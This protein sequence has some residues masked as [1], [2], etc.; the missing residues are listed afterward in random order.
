MKNSG[1]IFVHMRLSSARSHACR[2][3]VSAHVCGVQRSTLGVTSQKLSVHLVFWDQVLHLYLGAQISLDFLV[4]WVLLSTCLYPLHTYV[5]TSVGISSIGRHIWLF[6][7]V[8]GIEF[9]SSH[10]RGKDLGNRDNSQVPWMNTFSKTMFG[11]LSWRNNNSLQ[12]S[13]SC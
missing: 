10:L 7:W 4:H 3:N 13:G 9:R 6:P 12:W 11:L 8:V 5:H 1:W 2:L